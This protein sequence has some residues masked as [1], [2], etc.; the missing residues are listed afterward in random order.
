MEVERLKQIQR[1]EREDRI[2]KRNSASNFTIIPKK[3]A[4]SP[5]SEP[6]LIQTPSHKISHNVD[7]N[8]NMDNKGVNYF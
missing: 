1:E 8:N 3:K 2:A 6:N 4:V 5:T 7:P